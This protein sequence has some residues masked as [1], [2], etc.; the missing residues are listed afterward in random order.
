M[1]RQHMRRRE[2]SKP[3][4]GEAQSKKSRSPAEVA[5]YL[6]RFGYFHP[7]MNPVYR[8]LRLKPPLIAPSKA[9]SLADISTALKAYQHNM[10]LPTTGKL[11]ADTRKVLET[12]RCGVPDFPK[13]GT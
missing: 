8:E 4:A 1:K 11:D 7:A 13:R 2:R 6:E 3:A 12:P 9:R 10:G 5:K